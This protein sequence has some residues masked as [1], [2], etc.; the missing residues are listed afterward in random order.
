MFILLTA[1]NLLGQNVYYGSPEEDIAHSIYRYENNF[2]IV[3]TTCET[4]KSP[5]NYY[6]LQLFNNGSKKSEFVFGEIHRDVGKDIIVNAD[7]IYVFGKT[8]DGG[9]PNNDMVLS[10]LN[11][12]GQRE[13]KKYYGGHHNDLGH[14]F[15][16]AKDGGFVMVGH[17][18]SVDDFGDVYVVKADKNGEL[19][20]ENHFGE[21]F[22]DH[23]FDV[24]ENEDGDFIVAGTIGGFFNP[25]SSDYYNSN[26]DIFIIKVNA[27]GE[28]IWTKTLG[29]E[30]HDWAKGI[31][32]APD[33]GY[34]ICGSTQS[35]GAGSF[36]MFLIKIDEDGNQLWLKTFGGPEFE[37]G[38]Q[39]KLSED[40]NLFLLG[41]SASYSADYKTDHLLVKTD[42]DGNL[43]W[44]NNYGGTNSDYSSALVCTEDSGCV[45]T[46]WTL[47]GDFGGKD[48]VFIKILKDGTQDYLSLLPQIND[49]IEQIFVYPN[50]ARNRFIVKIDTRVTDQFYIDLYNVNGVPVYKKEISPNVESVHYLNVASGVY[51]Y[52]IRNNTEVLYKGRIMVNSNY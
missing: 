21:Q 25:T 23:G 3:G 22:V 36:D 45:F 13:W 41:T 19:I 33:G 32:A 27:A 15:I 8:W 26:A 18:R 35:E 52:T 42:L 28:E 40:N 24:V 20:W 38:E 9:F 7:G 48:I 46:G 44:S 39:V 4:D 12:N 17:N 10:K 6:V 37:Y 16:Q 30:Q 5:S 31:I 11:F 14:R 51:F 29:G 1:L 34:F 43:I 47:N 50:P 49:S 2:Y